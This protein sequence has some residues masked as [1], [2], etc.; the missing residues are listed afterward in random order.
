MLYLELVLIMSE[1]GEEE[2][3]GLERSREREEA[4]KGDLRGLEGA[5]VEEEGGE[6]AGME[7]SHKE[8]ARDMFE[9]ITEYLNGELAGVCVYS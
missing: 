5:V 8:L 9:K 4:T 1:G 3:D 7:D 6:G 2:V